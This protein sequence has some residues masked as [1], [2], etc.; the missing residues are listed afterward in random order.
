MATHISRRS[1]AGRRRTGWLFVALL[2]VALPALTLLASPRPAIALVSWLFDRGATRASAALAPHVPPGVATTTVQPLPGEPG[3][4]AFDLHRPAVTPGQSLPLIVWIHGGG[5]VSGSRRDVAAYASIVAARGFA[6]ATLDYTLAPDASYPAQLRQLN[7]ALARILREAPP[8]GLDVQRIVLA[9]DSAGAQLAAQ[10]AAVTT[11]PD[12]AR[13]VGVEPALEPAQVRGVLLFCGVYD[14][15]LLDFDG[16][17][18]PFLRAV[19]WGFLGARD[20]RASPAFDQASV[21]RHLTARFPPAFVT[22]G[23]GDPLL[24]QSRGMA[25]RLAGLGVPVETLFFDPALAPPLGHEYQFDLDRPEG[26]DALD[27]AVAFAMARL[28]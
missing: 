12:Y 26:R 1:P 20:F 19:A 9:G 27:R 25:A 4:K 21:L 11:A 23:N 16:P 28:R 10:L 17:L 15:G 5:F 22:A 6:V 8:L 3:S 14:F 13:A 2:V 7:A 24:P 18:G